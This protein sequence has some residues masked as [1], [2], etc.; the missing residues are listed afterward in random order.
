MLGTPKRDPNFENY[1]SRT[2][3]GT[4]IETR[5]DPFKELDTL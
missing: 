3:I 2:L 4:L 1:P 5:I